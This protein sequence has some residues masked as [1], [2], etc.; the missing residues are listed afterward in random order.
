MY[1]PII[2]TFLFP[3][4]QAETASLYAYIFKRRREVGRLRARPNCNNTENYMEVC[5]DF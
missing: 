2:I 4:I 3:A 1:R 5:Y